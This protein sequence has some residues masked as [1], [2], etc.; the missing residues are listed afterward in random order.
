M[1]ETD[2]HTEKETKTG[3]E[4]ERERGTERETRRDGEM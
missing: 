4:T 2:R 3:G 1:R